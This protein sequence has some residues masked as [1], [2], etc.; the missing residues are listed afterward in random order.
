MRHLSNEHFRTTV[1]IRCTE[2]DVNVASFAR[3][4]SD[5]Y[6]RSIC[7]VSVCLLQAVIVSKRIHERIEL[8]FGMESSF[9]LSLTKFGYL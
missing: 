9:D 6:P 4:V 2:L 3:F 7:H 5:L 8:I 1:G